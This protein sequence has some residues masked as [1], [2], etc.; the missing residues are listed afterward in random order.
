LKIEHSTAV[1][2]LI[3][4]QIEEIDE[5]ASEAVADEGTATIDN[6][7]MLSTPPSVVPGP[8]LR[9]GKVFIDGHVEL[10]S[11][12]PPAKLLSFDNNFQRRLAIW[13]TAELEAVGV[14][15]LNAI[16]FGPEDNVS[17]TRVSLQSASPNAV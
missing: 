13:L 11:Y 5:I 10:R 17:S 4:S 7:A 9:W 15:L 2:I 3:R 6:Q 16:K 14:P 1:S 12:Q 8:E